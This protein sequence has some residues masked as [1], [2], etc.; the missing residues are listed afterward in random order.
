MAESPGSIRGPRFSRPSGGGGSTPLRDQKRAMTLSR[1]A[2]A[3]SRR[4]T[5][6]NRNFERGQARRDEAAE[7][8]RVFRNYAAGL[9]AQLGNRTG[10][11]LAASPRAMT[12]FQNE[13]DGS[14][15]RSDDSLETLKRAGMS[16]QMIEDLRN[17]GYMTKHKTGD[18]RDRYS[19]A[20]SLGMTAAESE[21]RTFDLRSQEAQ[22]GK[23]EAEAGQ[24][25]GENKSRLDVAT[26]TKEGVIRSAEIL[27]EG[28]I[29][30]SRLAAEAS[31]HATDQGIILEKQKHKYAVQLQKFALASAKAEADLLYSRAEQTNWFNA[32]LEMGKMNLTHEL[33]GVTVLAEA[34][35]NSAMHPDQR[36]ELQRML[37][38][39]M[40]RLYGD[41]KNPP[42]VDV[43]EGM[44]KIFKILNAKKS[45]TTRPASPALANPAEAGG[46]PG[47]VSGDTSPPGQTKP[48]APPMPRGADAKKKKPEGPTVK[49]EEKFD[50]SVATSIGSGTWDLGKRS[51]H[52]QLDRFYGKDVV[53]GAIDDARAQGPTNPKKGEEGAFLWEDFVSIFRKHLSKRI[54]DKRA[55][56]K[57][58]SG[59][60]VSKGNFLRSAFSKALDRNF[61][62]S[63]EGLQM[64]IGGGKLGKWRRADNKL[65]GKK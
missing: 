22:T 53:K 59:E 46:R 62:P 28:G 55:S 41:A 38:D 39:R 60:K 5:H 17:T 19:E 63:G 1:K 20:Q 64:I 35:G 29:E 56:G 47:A 8:G 9:K 27:S 31:K 26:V 54:A 11:I 42:S 30:S 14:T 32:A 58:D 33:T 51:L 44:G 43:M 18:Q 24:I 13:R 12:A 3:E 48:A 36:Q 34:L 10:G 7:R 2:D 52:E 37:A 4:K 15:Q 61:G 16:P 23:T 25:A 6:F 65:G 57:K 49:G 40:K 21:Q 45:D 50:F